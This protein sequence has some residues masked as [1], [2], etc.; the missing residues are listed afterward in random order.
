MTVVIHL[1]ECEPEGKGWTR[2]EYREAR[3]RD[4]GMCPDVEYMRD[5][6]FPDEMVWVEAG[7]SPS[8]VDRG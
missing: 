7:P 6:L 4:G 8:T 5:E 2:E 1:A 3:E